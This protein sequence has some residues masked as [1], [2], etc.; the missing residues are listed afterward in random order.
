MHEI[1]NEERADRGERSDTSVGRGNRLWS[2]LDDFLTALI[3]ANLTK[4]PFDLPLSIL[5]PPVPLNVLELSHEPAS[6]P[7][8]QSQGD[9]SP[10]APHDIA[11]GFVGKLSA[12]SDDVLACNEIAHDIKNLLQAISSGVWVAE[13]RIREGRA[14]EVPQILGKIGEA[15]HRVNDCIRLIQGGAHSCKPGAFAVDIERTLERLEESLGWAIGSSNRLA[16]VVASGLPPIYCVESEFENVILNL[17]MNARDAMPGGGRAT[18][19]VV[20]CSRSEANDGIIFRVHDTGVGMSTE[21]AA[22]AF[23]PYF[24]T[25]GSQGTGLGLAMV[26]S[27]ARS[28]GGSAWIEHSSAGGT[29]VAMHLPGA[30]RSSIR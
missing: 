9:D 17:V 2:D 8:Y 25:K 12:Q 28:V 24:T 27:F 14:E 6:G 7:G 10:I 20:R 30:I 18:I 13:V 21:V 5:N 29:T 26:A 23:K 3:E 19:E 22:K 15:L 11:C 16:M 1:S 4:L